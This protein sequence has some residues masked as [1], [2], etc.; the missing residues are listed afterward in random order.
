MGLFW[1]RQRD[2]T[3][4]WGPGERYSPG[5]CHPRLPATFQ[6]DAHRE[7]AKWEMTWHNYIPVPLNEYLALLKIPL[8]LRDLE[9]FVFAVLYGRQSKKVSR[10][11]KYNRWHS[12]KWSVWFKFG[13]KLAQFINVNNGNNPR[14]E[15]WI[16]I[17][18]NQIK[19]LESDILR[20]ALY[21][22]G[23]REARLPMYK[24]E[25]TA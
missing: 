4:S 15:T 12:S 2:G 8:I 14:I 24:S 5:T 7:F 19:P 23:W 6:Q 13:M 10:K 21:L 1:V 11:K 9:D 22:Q 20:W 25:N 16:L 18:N 3:V 17:E